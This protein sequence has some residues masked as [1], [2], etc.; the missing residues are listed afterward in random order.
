MPNF[1]NRRQGKRQVISYHRF[2]PTIRSPQMHTQIGKDKVLY[3]G[4]V[5]TID[6]DFGVV[7][8]VC[9]RN[10]RFLVV[11]SNEEVR[12]SASPDA[13]MID[14]RGKSVVPGFV[15]SHNHIMMTQLERAKVSVVS[16]KSI[17]DLLAKSQKPK[18]A[19][20]SP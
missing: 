6:K 11:G 18:Q 15:D 14:L 7:Q 13:E 10:G 9:V 16:A 2:M 4:N 12:A 3:N 19:K 17:G 5:I 1:R 8:A 20:I